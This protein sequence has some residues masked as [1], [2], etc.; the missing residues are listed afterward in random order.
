MMKMVVI[1]HFVAESNHFNE[2]MLFIYDT[3]NYKLLDN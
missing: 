2:M 1:S 3:A